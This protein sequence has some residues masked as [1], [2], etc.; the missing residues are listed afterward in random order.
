MD[1]DTG[2]KADTVDGDI[3]AF[4]AAGLCMGVD[5]S[6]LR[7][8]APTTVPAGE[9]TSVAGVLFGGGVCSSSPSSSSHLAL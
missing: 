9:G 1:G 5:S 7:I 6:V 8:L 4:L 3:G 2:D